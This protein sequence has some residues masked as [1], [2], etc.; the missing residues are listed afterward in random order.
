MTTN[1]SSARSVKLRNGTELVFGRL[2]ASDCIE[3]EQEL[4]APLSEVGK[5]GLRGMLLLAWRSAVAGGFDKPFKAFASLIDMTDDLPKVTEAA[6]SFFGDAATTS[7]EE[8]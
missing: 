4:G 3:V 6:S 1:D 7:T 2:R 5:S 8:D